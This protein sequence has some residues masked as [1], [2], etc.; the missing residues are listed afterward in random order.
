MVATLDFCTVCGASAGAHYGACTG[1]P[2]PYDQPGPIKF[3]EPQTFDLYRQGRIS[4]T[5]VFRPWETVG[6]VDERD[7]KLF[8]T[9]W[10]EANCKNCD[11]RVGRRVEVEVVDQ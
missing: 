8:G 1:P 7:G 5:H 11:A 9:F 10:F 2:P 3:G 6:S 4:C